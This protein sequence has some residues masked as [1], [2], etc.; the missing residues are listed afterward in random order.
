MFNLAASLGKGGISYVARKFHI[1]R[2]T[3]HKAKIEIQN[4]D[5]YSKNDKIRIRKENHFL[6]DDEIQVIY[7][8][9]K[10]MN[11]KERREYLFK[12]LH[13]LEFKRG[14]L[15]FICKTFNINKKS[16]Y[17]AKNEFEKKS[18]PR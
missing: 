10:L 18:W 11:E 2:N 16:L 7:E 17:I 1:S 13:K 9:Q 6:T 12:I 3:L 14:S 15:N 4:N 5:I 8:K